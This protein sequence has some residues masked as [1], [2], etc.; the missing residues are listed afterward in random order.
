MNADYAA[1]ISQPCDVHG[2]TQFYKPFVLKIVEHWLLRHLCVI[3]QTVISL[4]RLPLCPLSPLKQRCRRKA[5]VAQDNTSDFWRLPPMMI[6]SIRLE[7]AR[8]CMQSSPIRYFDNCGFWISSSRVVDE[9]QPHFQTINR[10]Q[11][12]T[13]EISRPMRK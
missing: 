12:E 10:Y 3:K 4:R 11:H 5:V 13:G 2:S 6:S 9:R 1:I 8:S 7:E